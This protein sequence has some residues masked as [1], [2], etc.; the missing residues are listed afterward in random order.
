MAK[1]FEVLGEKIKKSLE[2]DSEKLVY[3]ASIY[4]VLVLVLYW[5]TKS[6]IVPVVLFMVA[7]IYL[8]VRYKCRI[9]KNYSGIRI[10]GYEIDYSENQ[11]I[12]ANK[13]GDA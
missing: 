6:R 12:Q 13:I 1:L 11:K 2:Y 7:I 3:V 8:G 10:Q 4:F 5:F 9:D